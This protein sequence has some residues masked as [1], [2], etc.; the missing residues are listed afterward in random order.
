MQLKIQG[1]KSHIREI[2]GPKTQ[3][4]LCKKKNTTLGQKKKNTIMP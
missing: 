3:L 1:P 2:M 4:C